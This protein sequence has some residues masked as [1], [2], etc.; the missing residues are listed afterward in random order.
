V[1]D[2]GTSTTDTRASAAERRTFRF[3]IEGDPAEAMKVVL[4]R[5]TDDE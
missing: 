3:R 4:A 5:R 1:S 2:E